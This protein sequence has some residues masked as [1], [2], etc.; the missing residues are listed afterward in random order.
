MK[1]TRLLKAD[2]F[3]DGE[4][5]CYRFPFDVLDNIK[6]GGNLG[7]IEWHIEPLFKYEKR[8]GVYRIN[9]FLIWATQTR[10]KRYKGK[11]FFVNIFAES[12]CKSYQTDDYFQYI[13]RMGYCKEHKTVSFSAYPEN[14]HRFLIIEATSSIS[15]HIYFTE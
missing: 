13:W 5:R 2:K 11:L 7:R 10:D 6:G 12:I 8:G 14:H 15:N 9:K 3:Y 4:K 1:T